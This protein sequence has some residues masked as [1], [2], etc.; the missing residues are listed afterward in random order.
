MDLSFFLILILLF[1]LL[2][3]IS[4]RQLVVD[5]Y[6]PIF[7]FESEET[8]FPVNGDYH[9]QKSYFYKNNGKLISITP[10]V[11]LIA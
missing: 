3:F 8:C 4:L 2:G 1:L 6:A 10:A 7:Y 5:Q 11:S 9:L